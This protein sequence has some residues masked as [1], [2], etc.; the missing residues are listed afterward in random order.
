MTDLSFCWSRCFD[1]GRDIDLR[2]TE[3]VNGLLLCPRCY[4]SR[5][6]AA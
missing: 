4:Q 1:C 6:G 5:R 3:P 2:L